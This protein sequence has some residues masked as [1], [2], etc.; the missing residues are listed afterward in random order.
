MTKFDIYLDF[1]SI[2]DRDAELEK[3][4]AELK[5]AKS[6]LERAD[7]MLSNEAFVSKAPEK[8]IAQEKEKKQKYTDM[9]EKIEEKISKLK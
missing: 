2:V 7:K 8:L 3:L 1:S 6:E 5:K 9:I 4:N